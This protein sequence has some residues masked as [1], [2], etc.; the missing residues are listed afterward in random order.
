MTV[1][2]AYAHCTALARAH[3]ENFP[4]GR[5]VPGHLQKH[6]HAVYAFAR[7]ADDMADEGYVDDGMLTGSTLQLAPGERLTPDQR[8]LALEEWQSHLTKPI[9]SSTPPT[10]I[11]V[12][13]TIQDLDLP[14][15]LFT[16]LISAFKQDV[17]KR[18][19]ANFAEVLDYCRRSANPVGRLVLLL[20]G[21]RDEHQHWMSDQICTALQLANFWQD[22][23]VDLRKDR[24]YLPQEDREAFGVTEEDLFAHRATP[25]FRRLMRFQVDRTQSIFDQGEP[26]SATLPGLL[27]WEIRL[28]WL[29]GASVLRKIEEQ[30][31]DTLT[32]RPKVEK[33]EFATLFAQ[34]WL[35]A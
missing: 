15:S 17:V 4:V 5:L 34:A 30:N 32:A 31:Y 18:R 20:H 27:Q 21:H 7:Y 35:S 6:V 19:Y 23:S 13:A 12:Q 26:L 22:V 10:F 1:E 9:S 8:L 33:T 2:E 25:G 11:A 14:I 3:Y 28:T 16:D 29:G 24:I